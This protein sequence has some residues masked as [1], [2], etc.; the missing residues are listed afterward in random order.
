MTELFMITQEQ[1]GAPF[2]PAIHIGTFSST[3]TAIIYISVQC[4]GSLEF[5]EANA[6]L[7]IAC[8]IALCVNL[9][10]L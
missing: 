2:Y 10:R 6:C 9:I 8:L 1:A 3:G 5:L 7:L 4:L